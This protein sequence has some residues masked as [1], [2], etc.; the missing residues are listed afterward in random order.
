MS[1]DQLTYD[2]EALQTLITSQDVID[3]TPT[4][5]HA[6]P[7][8]EAI[9]IQTKEEK[10]FNQSLGM[11]LYNEMFDARVK[12]R[13]DTTGDE[14]YLVF[15]RGVNYTSGQ[16]V[17]GANAIYQ[18]VQNTDGSQTPP[19]RYYFKLA[20]KFNFAGNSEKTDAFNFLWFRY[21]KN[22]IAWEV[23]YGSVATKLL[24]VTTEIKRTSSNNGERSGSNNRVKEVTFYRSE[25]GAII[26]QMTMNMHLYIM[27]NKDHF[28]KYKPLM[29]NQTGPPK[30]RKRRH[31]GINTN[32]RY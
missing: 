2:F 7:N 26:D 29:E 18:V 27:R 10:L 14:Q 8:Y 19:Q 3:C 30:R 32:G 28:K 11:E 4:D 1:I 13:L 24:R 25:I 31:F 16:F 12:Y 5:D 23:M 15:S 17:F 9:F 22:L 21:L 20:N 6:T